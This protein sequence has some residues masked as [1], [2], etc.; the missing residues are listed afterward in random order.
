M[1]TPCA[2]CGKPA[3]T[4]TSAV[5]VNPYP[6]FIKAGSHLSHAEGFSGAKVSALISATECAIAMPEHAW[7]ADPRSPAGY[8]CAVGA[9]DGMNALAVAG[10]GTFQTINDGKT[11][12]RTFIN[13]EITRAPSDGRTPLWYISTVEG[14]GGYGE[15]A[16]AEH[17][18]LRMYG[19][20]EQFFDVR[21]ASHSAPLQT[22]Y[23]F[24]TLSE[25]YRSNAVGFLPLRPHTH[26]HRLSCPRS[27]TARRSRRSM[28]A[29][30][31]RGSTP[32]TRLRSTRPSPPPSLLTRSSGSSLIT[33]CCTTTCSHL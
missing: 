4:T 12:M 17:E 32:P 1:A 22:L 26:T 11:Y 33:R 20:I 7:Q 31:S 18:K 10:D 8:F 24:S 25:P 3:N 13:T 14:K 27:L 15:P 21:A 9:F 2:G 23:P 30:R 28:A 5:E 29:T 6:L 16:P 19:A